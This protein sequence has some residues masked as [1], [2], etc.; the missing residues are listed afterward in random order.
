MQDW[1]DADLRLSGTSSGINYFLFAGKHGLYDTAAMNK[2]FEALLKPLND[3]IADLDKCIAAPRTSGAFYPYFGM[4]FV[5]S[6]AI[7]SSIPTPPRFAE[8][9]TIRN[10]LAFIGQSSLIQKTTLQD[11]I[12]GAS[13]FTSDS[14]EEVTLYAQTV[15]AMSQLKDFVMRLDGF[16]EIGSINEMVVK[17]VRF[18][19][20]NLQQ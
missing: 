19:F 7:L 20:F 17:K 1:G 6:S 13:V 16:I 3:T 15:K 12:P 14:G 2:A 9:I 11:F 5:S 18:V 10:K 4:F 8:K